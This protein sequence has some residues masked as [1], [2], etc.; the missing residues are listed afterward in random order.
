MI[1]SVLILTVFPSPLDVFSHDPSSL[2]FIQLKK[3]Y[4][5]DLEGLVSVMLDFWP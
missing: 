4:G 1:S 2:R 5:A 3:T